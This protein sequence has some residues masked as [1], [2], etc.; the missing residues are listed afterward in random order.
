MPWPHGLPAFPK[1]IRFPGCFVVTM[2]L[3]LL[4][5]PAF[6][7]IGLP[8]Q[9]RMHSSRHFA[10]ARMTDGMEMME[11]GPPV[12]LTNL[13]LEEL[14]ELQI[15]PVN[16]LGAHTHRKG[17]I[18]FGYQYMNMNMVGNLNGTRR[19]SIPEVLAAYPIAHTDMRMEMH[20]FELMYSPSDRSTVML[21]LPYK[22]MS[23]GHVNRAGQS[24]ST[25][26][27]GIGDLELMGN[28]TVWGSSA[29]GHRLLVNAGVSFPTGGINL[30]HPTPTSPNA[31]LEYMMQL[32]SG[33]YDVMPGLTYLG[34]GGNWAW[35]A[36][37]LAT[38]RL[39]R[40][41]NQYAL[42]DR[43]RFALWSYYK[44]TDSFGPS[45]RFEYNDWGNVRGA[46]AELNP[47]ANPAFDASLQSG[48]RLD[49]FFGLNLYTPRG[50][51]K[52]H[53]FSLEMGA[54]LFQS[55]SGPNNRMDFQWMLSWSYTY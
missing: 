38:L 16:V 2:A 46:D 5:L 23:M 12:D 39:G 9:G 35:G 30:R 13:S 52:G 49:L 37:A 54:P 36:Q 28:Y 40:N 15:I 50:K 7:Q 29:R 31:K 25:A 43:L 47:A 8:G 10:A 34:E 6:G 21:M 19:V 51:F 44:V 55:L 3:L 41:E 33:T 4:S 14:L 27:H 32:G 11:Q 26:S 20:M 48:R 17:E 45:L 53:R 22:E 18:M 1:V 42:G 24:F